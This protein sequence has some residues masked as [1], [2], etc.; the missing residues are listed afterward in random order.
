MPAIKS[1]SEIAKKWATVTPG[2]SGDY[3]QG[4]RNPKRSWA[5]AT[6]AAEGSY[7]DAVVKAANEGR[8]GKGVKAAGDE[9]WSKGATEKGT[10]RWGPGVQIAEGNFSQGF[11]PYASVISALTLPPR[12]PK[13]DPRN[14]Q[15][16]AAMADALHKAKV[17]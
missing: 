13:G 14:I 12:Y 5:T 1:A 10:Q 7:K 16:V 2:R 4:V 9:A 17:K 8:F 11:A 3:E 15:R 6:S